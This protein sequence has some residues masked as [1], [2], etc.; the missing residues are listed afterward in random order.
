MALL[1]ALAAAD[2]EVVSDERAR[3]AEDAGGN[4]AAVVAFD[5]ICPSYILGVLAS[6]YAA[7]N[8]CPSM[9]LEQTSWDTIRG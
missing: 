3:L 2:F 9:W 5:A 8:A 4:I 6:E 1:V 7:S